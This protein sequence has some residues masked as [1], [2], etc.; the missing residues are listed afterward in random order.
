MNNQ[1]SLFTAFGAGL[2][3]F[4]SPCVLSL[5]PVYL[6]TL[7]TFNSMKKNATFVSDGN[8]MKYT[9][10]Q[11]TLNAVMFVGGI[12]L[13]FVLLS[14]GAFSV[15]L[16]LKEHKLFL[17]KVAALVVMAMAVFAIASNVR[18]FGFLLRER[19]LHFKL[20]HFKSIAPFLMGLSFGLG[21]IPCVSPVLASILAIASVKTDIISAIGLLVFYGLGLGLPFVAFGI[22]ADNKMALKLLGRF[23]KTLSLLGALGLMV[24]GVLLFQGHFTFINSLF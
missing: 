19:R 1:V 16:P 10:R 20:K 7:M 6:T 13:I 4:I 5:V 11:F 24:L 8:A 3:S 2:I 23:S 15:S 18:P 22:L 21:W 12:I 9:Y 17:E 14:L